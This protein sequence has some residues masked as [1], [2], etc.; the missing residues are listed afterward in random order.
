MSYLRFPHF[1]RVCLVVV[2]FFA[3][4]SFGFCRLNFKNFSLF[5]I[6]G[7]GIGRVKKTETQKKKNLV[8]KVFSSE[9]MLSERGGS[10]VLKDCVI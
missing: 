2:A 10:K 5:S 4:F 9:D 1:C 7:M 8:T 3:L 6:E